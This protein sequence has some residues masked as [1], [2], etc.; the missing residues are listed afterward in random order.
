VIKGKVIHI[1]DT[2][3][4]YTSYEDSADDYGRFLNENKRY[5][6]AFAFTSDPLKFVA[7]IAKAGYATDPNYAKS[8]T[9]IIVGFK[10]TQ[11]D[12]H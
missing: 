8:L 3:R 6:A 7:A 1:K 9:S 5:R 11:Y 4:A 10:L 12:T 2:F